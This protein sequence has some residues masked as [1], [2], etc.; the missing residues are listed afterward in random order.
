MEGYIQKAEK[1]LSVAEKLL[2]SD[3]YEDAIS[4][5]YWPCINRSIPLIDSVARP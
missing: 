3:D 4:R 5:A 2:R 1:K